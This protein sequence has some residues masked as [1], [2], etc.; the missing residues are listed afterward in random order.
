MLATRSDSEN[1]IVFKDL[2]AS[3]LAPTATVPR[4]RDS[5]FFAILPDQA[6]HGRHA[7]V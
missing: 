3:K 5:R 6:V 2:F 4:F 7:G 1:I